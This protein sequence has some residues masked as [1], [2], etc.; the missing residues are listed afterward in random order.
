M[1]C[2][3]KFNS[4]MLK[5]EKKKKVSLIP[6]LSVSFCQQHYVRITIYHVVLM[7]MDRAWGKIFKPY[8]LGGVMKF[9]T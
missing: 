9:Q 8:L 2:Y 7:I 1:L 6:C 5:R 4:K 3:D